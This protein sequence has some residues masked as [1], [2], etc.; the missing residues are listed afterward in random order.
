M[1]KNTL[2]VLFI[3]TVGYLLIAGCMDEMIEEQDRIAENAAMVN[4]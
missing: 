4:Q 1:I 2:L 3:A